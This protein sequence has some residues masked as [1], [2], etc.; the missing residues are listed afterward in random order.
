MSK[1]NKTGIQY[2]LKELKSLV[3]KVCHFRQISLYHNHFGPKIFTQ[4]QHVALLILYAKSGKSLRKF[5]SWLYESRW[6]EWL[7]LNEIP[8]KS[9]IHFHF[10]RIGLTL[11]RVLNFVVSRIKKTLNY[12]I[13]STGIDASCASRH[14]TKRIERKNNDFLK[15]S[16]LASTQKPYLID[17]FIAE[18]SRT[19]DVMHGKIL[20]KRFNLK[21]KIIFGDKAYDCEELRQIADDNSNLIYSPIRKSSR[22]RPGGRLRKKM[23]DTFCKKTYNRGRNPV[24]MIMFLFKNGGIVIRSK[25]RDNRIKE[26][27]WKILAYNIQRLAQSLLKLLYFQTT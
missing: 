13:D 11:L 9:T 25:K 19:N 22:N 3:Q 8:S 7:K 16:I 17:D 10:E 18:Y 5:V 15:V 27:G 4:H 23:F 26:V 1:H 2:T 6:P 14:Y 21:N 24:E 12:A 20:C